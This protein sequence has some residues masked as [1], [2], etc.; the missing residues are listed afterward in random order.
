MTLVDSAT[1]N[2]WMASPYALFILGLLAFSES[3]FFLIPPEVMVIP[4]GLAK[5]EL[6]IWY[7]VFIS[8]LS[9][10]GAA[11]GYFIGKK[12]G[13]PVLK[14]LFKDEH[15]DAVRRL[16]QKY[17]TKAIFIAA[18]TPIPYKV[19][20][21]SAGVFDL[22]FDRFIITSVIGRSARYLLLTGLIAIFGEAV[23][24]FIENQLDL[25]IGVGTAVLVGGAAF[26]KLGI[27][28]IE[29]KILKQ[30]LKSKLAGL[31]KHR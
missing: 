10:A 3:S 15:I 14:K 12:G 19:F 1:L 13:K 31:F 17:D 18:F 30:S 27:P 8:L 5:P 20:T 16:F 28:F 26:Y 29:N 6:A 9:L 25:A 7:G 4:M 11:F 23:R 22:K 21:I 24:S 2:M